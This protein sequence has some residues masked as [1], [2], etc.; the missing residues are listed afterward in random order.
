MQSKVRLLEAKVE[1]IARAGFRTLTGRPKL[2]I[3]FARH[4]KHSPVV[5][6]RILFETFHGKTIGDSP[7][8]MLQELMAQGRAGDFQIYYATAHPKEHAALVRELGLPVKLV[9]IE[10]AEYA[11]VL[12]TAKYLVNNSSFPAFF[13]RRPEQRYIQTW[14]GTPL[15][16][17]GKRMRLGIESMYNVQHNFLQASVLTFPNEFTRDVMMRDYN[18]DH[19]YTGTV[20]LLG[21]PRNTVF[22][23]PDEGAA[24]LRASYGLDGFEN[25]AYMPTWRG[26][27][28]HDIQ[29]EEY[30]KEVGAILREVDAQLR[31]DQR[32]WVNFHSMVAADISLDAYEHIRPFPAGVDNYRFLNQMDALITDYSSV[33]FD[34]SL[35]RKPVVLFP[36]DID[37]YTA[38]R[39]FYFDIDELPFQR[40]DTAAELAQTLVSGVFRSF[41]YKGSAYEKD[42][43]SYDS[44]QNSA[45]ALRLLFDD[46][47]PGVPIIDYDR[48]RAKPRRAI[49]PWEVMH[50]DDIDTICKAALRDDAV[51]L[52]PLTGFTQGMSANL[53]D[54]YIDAF[55]YMFI[56][57]QEP[58]TVSEKLASYV[59]KPTRDDLEARE[60]TRI[61]ADLP[62][63]DVTRDVYYCEVGLPYCIDEGSSFQTAV[64][65][66]GD[67]FAI[68]LS[69]MPEG[70]V[71]TRV[72]L[73]SKGRI[74][75]V[76]DLTQE[77]VD[78]RCARESFRAALDDMAHVKLGQ[79]VTVCVEGVDGDGI[80]RLFYLTVA[81]KKVRR[82]KAC[83][84]PLVFDNATFTA[85]PADVRAF[86]NLCTGDDPAIAPYVDNRTQHVSLL[87]STRTRYAG[88]FLYAALRYVHC[89][90][91]R[92]T[93]TVSARM[94]AGDFTVR[95]VVFSF[96]DAPD[97][98]HYEVPFSTSSFGEYLMVRATVDLSTANLLETYWDLRI[99]VDA[100]GVE[101]EVPFR[102]ST[103]K[104]ALL[105]LSNEQCF[106]TDDHVIFPY[107]TKNGEMAF[108]YRART[109]FD[110]Y[111]TRLKE[112]AAFAVFVLGHP[113]WRNYRAWLVFEK[114][115]SLAQDNGYY[116]FKYCME[117]LPASK[118]KNIYYVIKKDAPDYQKLKQFGRNVVPFMS[119]RH[120]LL[121]L[122][123]SAYVGSD[124]RSHVYQ[125]RPKPNL[126]SYRVAYHKILFLQHGVTAMKRVDYLFGR[127]GTSPMTYFLTTSK[128]EQDIVT[129]NF[130]YSEQDAPICGFA[131][132]DALE[133]RSDAAHP[134]ILLMPTWRPWLEDKTADYFVQSDYFRRYSELIQ[135]PRLERFLEDN[136]ATLVF[137]IHPKL[138]DQL[139]NFQTASERVRLVPM[140]SQPLNEVMMESTALITDYSSVCWDMLYMRKPVVYYQFDQDR[141]LEVTGSYVD[142]NE[143][144]P[145]D[146]CKGTDELFASLEAL[147]ARGFAL[148]A[149]DAAL[150]DEWFDARD[151]NN[152]KR[153]YRYLVSRG[154]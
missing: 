27:S 31:D 74:D 56:S 51:A 130:G 81:G 98:L 21:Y 62:V 83:C 128:R 15:K 34:F 66:D 6:N 82:P 32:I 72:L 118:R 53:H 96:R 48:N 89:S 135:D 104:K 115:C 127:H 35:T 58:W 4:Y 90:T 87:L 43:L 138:A 37:D 88:L 19:L 91:A 134:Q 42:Y 100:N 44:V 40:V 154:V 29:V 22:L 111:G 125:W 131:R 26:T 150:A 20:A 107:V 24:E 60:R 41:D 11:K 86:I 28:N 106:P 143:D 65:N 50:E 141:Y 79:R 116:F 85:D 68:D 10:S 54:N 149:D 23:A 99:I 93:I 151:T 114:F 38:D 124:S 146:V 126:I 49:D 64:T 46:E 142:L 47:A 17:L 97:Q 14:H 95:R 59:H 45:L 16:T 61:F 148:D 36:Y 77:E 144:L 63:T 136:D 1:R 101:C 103:A 139:A 84:E 105:V 80:P 25:F 129:A 5:E 119:F 9:S 94:D 70:Y 147:A 110:G 39:G 69:Q 30:A 92:K 12:A 76:R 121:C 117:Q 102:L 2:S 112:L 73:A 57:R 33:F 55:D 7:L 132:W 153:I 18:L 108:S 67:A 52:F 113:F 145:G 75:W 137:Y 122:T 152:C 123:A 13:I 140:G 3:V 133:D 71:P 120:M 8:Y 78:A 109:E